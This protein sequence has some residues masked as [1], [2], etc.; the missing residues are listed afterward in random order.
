M[1][2]HSKRRIKIVGKIG[3]FFFRIYMIIRGLF[4]IFIINPFKRWYN[5]YIRHTYIPANSRNEELLDYMLD[6]ANDPSREPVTPT[7][8]F[9]EN[10]IRND[11]EQTFDT[12]NTNEELSWEE[13]RQSMYLD[14]ATEMMS[15]RW[16]R[17]EDWSIVR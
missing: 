16:I 17:E 11:Y 3:D 13:I 14:L 2:F 8:I 12:F 4:T 15:L 9:F 5:F 1:I 6:V 7:E 10:Q